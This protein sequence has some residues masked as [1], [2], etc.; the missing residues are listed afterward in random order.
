[1]AGSVWRAG[2]VAAAA[3]WSCP[4][5]AADD[6]L[7]RLQYGASCAQCH[8]PTGQG[9]G[10]LAQFLTM[11]PPDLTGLQRANG[12]VFPFARTYEIIENGGG[13]GEH[14]RS[15]MPAWGDR[16]L[17][18]AYLAD[19]VTIPPEAQADFVRAR[20]LALI[21]HLARLQEP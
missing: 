17:L 16:L 6:T 15:D 12:G 13:I 9:D 5:V 20:I 7:G 1:M 19:G 8:G 10:P 4:A 3:I 2:I 21:D 18:E 11:P 14:G